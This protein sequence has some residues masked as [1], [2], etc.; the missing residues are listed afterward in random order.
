NQRETIKLLDG[1]ILDGRNRYRVC[2]ELGI[3]PRT[4]DLPPATDPLDYVLDVNLHR[5]HLTDVQRAF[6]A[7]SSQRITALYSGPHA[8]GSASQTVFWGPINALVSAVDTFAADSGQSVQS[9]LV[10]LPLWDFLYTAQ[11]QLTKV[12]F[13]PGLLSWNFSYF[14]Q[15]P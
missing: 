4:E 10:G 15:M 12:I 8:N 5:R 9:F 11:G 3:E 6:V 7:A 13:G 1:K 14:G 2:L